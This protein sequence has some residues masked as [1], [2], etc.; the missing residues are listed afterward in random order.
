MT[1]DGHSAVYMGI[2]LVDGQGRHVTDCDEKVRG[3]VEGAGSLAAFGFANPVTAENYTKGEFT[4][5]NGYATAI[6]RGGY[7]VEAANY[8]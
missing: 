8:L 4:T 7:M 6:V 3:I 1:A 5:F 2:E